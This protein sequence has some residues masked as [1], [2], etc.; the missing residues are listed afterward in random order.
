[1]SYS[2]F[3]QLKDKEKI[4]REARGKTP[5]LQQEIK[6][7]WLC[8]RGV[9]Q[10]AQSSLAMTWRLTGPRQSLSN[11]QPTNKV[12]KQRFQWL[13]MEKKYRL[14]RISSEKLLKKEQ[15]MGRRESLIFTVYYLK[16]LVFNNNKIMVCTSKL[17]SMGHNKE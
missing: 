10:H 3:K 16:C 15:T 12:T 6:A 1:M 11:H 2:N 9:L 7:S 5:H 4:M 13:C 14:H 8:V 17:E